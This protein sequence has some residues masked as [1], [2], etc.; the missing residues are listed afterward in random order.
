MSL[1]SCEKCW[2]DVC[3]CG[4]QHRNWSWKQIYNLFKGIIKYKLCQKNKEKK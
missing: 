4:Y 1:A 2:D 3:C